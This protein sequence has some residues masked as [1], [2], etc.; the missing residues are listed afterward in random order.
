[1]LRV[2]VAVLAHEVRPAIRGARE[3]LQNLECRRPGGRGAKVANL[4]SFASMPPLQR[5][6]AFLD[7]LAHLGRHRRNFAVVF[8]APLVSNLQCRR[9]VGRGAFG[10]SP[11]RLTVAAANWNAAAVRS[12][13]I[14]LIES[15]AKRA[16]QRSNSVV[17]GSSR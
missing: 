6:R 12:W 15:D 10:R 9:P 14:S 2:N 13:P 17:N 11:L 4:A 3:Q 7:P 16:R 1:M 8:S 5:R